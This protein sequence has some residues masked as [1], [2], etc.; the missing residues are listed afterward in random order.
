VPLCFERT[1]FDGRHRSRGR[2]K[3]DT[4]KGKGKHNGA[5]LKKPGATRKKNFHFFRCSQVVATHPRFDRPRNMLIPCSRSYRD[6]FFFFFL[7]TDPQPDVAPREP[8]AAMCVRNVDVQCVLQFTLIHA[9][10]CVLHRPTSRVIH[11]LELSDLLLSGS[12]I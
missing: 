2:Y 5:T 6:G 11:R 4:A 9:V 1:L 12:F 7:I 8:G 10:G 3:S